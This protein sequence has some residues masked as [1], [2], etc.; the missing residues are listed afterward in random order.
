MPTRNALPAELDYPPFRARVPWLGADLQTLRNFLAGPRAPVAGAEAG[1]LI[2][3]MPDGTGDRLT[4]ALSQGPAVVPGRPLVVLV[5]G[6]SG[7]EESVYMLESE[8]YFLAAGYRVLRLNLRGSAPTQPHCREQYH[9]GRDDDLAAVLDQ[10]V[11]RSE[12]ADGLVLMGFSLGANM[13]LRF[14]AA[15]GRDYPVR[16]AVS[17]SAPIDLAAA[18]ERLLQPR[19]RLYHGWILRHMKADAIA[20][21]GLGVREERVIRTCRTIYEFDDRVVA[22]NN[23]FAGAR[24]YYSRCSAIRFLADIRVPTLVIHALNDPWIPGRAYLEVDWSANPYLTPLLPMAG[25]HVGFHD[26]KGTWHNRMANLFLE[27]RGGVGKL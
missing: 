4:G 22:P 5:H 26:A 6:L 19:N 27:K 13:L 3:T 9:A 1:R 18:S 2:F 11:D 20:S 24:D 25:G 16:A 8:R 17:V 15:R 14:L 10:L 7:C 21:K 12:A 23:G